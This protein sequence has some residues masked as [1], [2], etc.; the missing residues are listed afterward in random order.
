MSDSTDNREDRLADA[1]DLFLQ[2]RAAGASDEELLEQCG[3]L[4][5]FL[6]PML[7]S[8]D[9][10]E[11][12]EAAAAA[13]EPLLGEG[14]I[15]GDFRVGAEI[16][17]GGM[18][19]VF[20]AHQISL[21]RPVALKVLLPHLTIGASQ[22]ARFRSEAANAARLRHPSIVPI[23]EVGEVGGVHFFAM[24]LVRGERLDRY[25]ESALAAHGSMAHRVALVTELVAQVADALD[26]AHQSGIVHRDVKPHNILVDQ[27]R[28]KLLDFGL[29]KVVDV[30]SGTRSG[31]FVG[32]PQYVSPEQA[33][34]STSR[35]GPHSD[36]FSLGVVLYE[37]LASARPFSGSAPEDVLQAVVRDE[38]LRL[39]AVDPSIPRDLE[40]ICARALEKDIADRYPGAQEMA[41][42]LR[43]FLRHE[44]IR[45]RRIGWLGR[46]VRFARRRPAVVSSTSLAALI[47]IGT[48]LGYAWHRSVTEQERLSRAQATLSVN[49][50]YVGWIELLRERVQRVPE[51]SEADR[52]E[53]DR[54]ID[55][56]R[57]FLA[58]PTDALD[59]V[60][61]V[62]LL[63]HVTD[64]L[65][66]V[67]ELD[68]A[69]LIN[70]EAIDVVHPLVDG[71]EEFAELLLW[72]GTLID[73]R[74]NLWPI[75]VGGTSEGVELFERAAELFARARDG[76]DEDL[77]PRAI[78]GLAKLQIRRGTRLAHYRGKQTASIDHLT[79]G[80]DLYEELPDTWRLQSDQLLGRAMGLNRRADLLWAMGRTAE[81][82]HDL[83]TIEA[84]LG[85]LDPED[86][87]VR[88]E[89][90]GATMRRAEIHRSEQERQQ[91]IDQFTIAA[92][93][94]RDL[95]D[96][97][98]GNRK[99]RSELA[100]SLVN[101]GVYLVQ[102][103]FYE[104]GKS[105]L[106]EARV[107]ARSV[108]EGSDGSEGINADRQ[109]L[110]H[111]ANAIASCMLAEAYQRP[112][113]APP[114]AARDLLLE[115]EVERR[116]LVERHPENVI[117]RCSLAR[118]RHDLACFELDYGTAD[119]AVEY[120]RAAIEGQELAL[121]GSPNS[122]G[123]R[124]SLGTHWGALANAE[125]K[126]GRHDAAIEAARR[127]LTFGDADR[128]IVCHAAE[129]M[130]R[131]ASAIARDESLD[132]DA[133]IARVDEVVTEGLGWLGNIVGQFPSAVRFLLSEPTFAMFRD[134]DDFDDLMRRA[135]DAR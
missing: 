92:R 63:S 72:A 129:G 134:R 109:V 61:G 132:R 25:V 74:L 6:E 106:Q 46:F 24:E 30:D 19:A 8:R 21:D 111:A 23:Y 101:L 78:I 93:M 14:A 57:K 77:A 91:A 82:V 73:Q 79:I 10:E 88:I 47:L 80:I 20:E 127:A 44:P 16:G 84:I 31:Q 83:D 97:Q 68:R 58:G 112:D 125:G 50:A 26:Y 29:S 86:A 65:H 43:A 41:A 18:G 98:P 34:G 1:I 81:A 123:I 103:G 114:F 113:E 75:E 12:P 4:R 69:K 28:A 71:G 133:R 5:E 116:A 32:T 22:I 54:L 42:D 55:S 95:V 36:V 40:T 131:A 126:A 27:G 110:A 66:R 38:P 94:L 45:A 100:K 49:H 51:L 115:A 108:I 102:L 117:Y 3:D 120:A 33:L 56:V 59:K 119:R 2:H 39:R 64:V 67:G 122:P 11:G 60:I 128:V 107:V 70:Q 76:F 99:Y 62:Q 53:L 85:T 37:L 96:D 17:R 104:K 13:G 87:R 121:S 89:I 7:D 15:L 90:A 9:G 105:A 118:T 35:I 124:M 130:I 52:Q 135:S 48:P